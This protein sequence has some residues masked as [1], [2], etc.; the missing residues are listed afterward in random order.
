[1]ASISFPRLISAS[2]PDPTLHLLR[3]SLPLL[4][5]LHLRRIS[6]LGSLPLARRKYILSNPLENGKQ[7]FPK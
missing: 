4:L 2:L 3:T 5:L 7:I 6:L 1:M